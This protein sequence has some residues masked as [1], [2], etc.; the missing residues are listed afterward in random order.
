M[1]LTVGLRGLKQENLTYFV[2]IARNLGI[3]LANATESIDFH[4]TLSSGGKK[5]SCYGTS[6]D[7][8][9]VTIIP[10]L[11]SQNSFSVPGLTQEQSS[12]LMALLQNVQLNKTGHNANALH[13]GS[14][15]KA[16]TTAFTSSAGTH[17]TDQKQNLC[18]LSSISDWNNIWIVDTRASDCM[19]HNRAPL[20]N[21][22]SLSKPVPVTLP[23]EKSVNDYSRTVNLSSSVALYGALY[24]PSF[25][26]N[27]LSVSKFCNQR[28]ML[29]GLHSQMLCH[30]GPFSEEA[31]GS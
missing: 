31:S 29:Y 17:I 11:G 8:E 24:I 10:T 19:C 16:P 14:K 12:Q 15:Y 7:Q 30:A 3:L 21:L 5:N 20:S 27:L 6:N 2:T 28:G 26:Y 18:L 4:Q 13:Q 1:L 23:N 25:K 9:S 22:L